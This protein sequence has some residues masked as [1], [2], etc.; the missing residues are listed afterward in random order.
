MS[1]KTE[2]EINSPPVNVVCQG[3]HSSKMVLEIKTT[4]KWGGGTQSNKMHKFALNDLSVSTVSS[5]IV[6]DTFLKIPA[7]NATL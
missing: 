5:K 4:L 2:Q 3:C 7:M 1:V 6:C